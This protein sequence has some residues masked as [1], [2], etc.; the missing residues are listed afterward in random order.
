MIMKGDEDMKKYYLNPNDV[1][2]SIFGM[3]LT[4]GAFIA[5]IIFSFFNGES[6]NLSNLWIIIAFLLFSLLLMAPFVYH[7]NKFCGYMYVDDDCLILKKGKK[8]TTIEVS[9]IRWIELKYDTRG[10]NGGIGQQKD[11]RF[12][13]RLN[14][15]KQDL[16]FIIT[17]QIIL[18]VIKKHNIRIMPDY[19]NQIYINTGKFDFR[20]K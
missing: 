8:Q 10:V 20:S 19:Y 15:H 5:L 2:V 3:L 13:I 9:N 12:S 6:I 17:N 18:D 7:L 1:F 16:D 4:G 14:N 11:F